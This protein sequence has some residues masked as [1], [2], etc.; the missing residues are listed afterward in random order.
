MPLDEPLTE[1]ERMAFEEIY[2]L[3]LRAMLQE[4]MSH[5]EIAR[6][7]G[8]SNGDEWNIYQR[9]LAK[10]RRYANKGCED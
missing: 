10:M 2:V 4:P 7:L 6:R 3:M 5:R 1:N 8:I 9:A